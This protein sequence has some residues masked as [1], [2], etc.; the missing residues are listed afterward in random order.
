MLFHAGEISRCAGISSR[1]QALLR[2]ALELN[3]AFS[4]PFASVARA[5]V[6]EGAAR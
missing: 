2:Q 1:G 6:A 5:H 4:V 3:P